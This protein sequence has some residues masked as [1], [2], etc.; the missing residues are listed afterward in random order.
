MI[1][2]LHRSTSSQL[3]RWTTRLLTGQRWSSLPFLSHPYS[4]CDRKPCYLYL[5]NRS[6]I[7]PL[8]TTS[9]ASSGHQSPGLLQKPPPH[10]PLLLPSLTRL[11]WMTS[12][13]GNLVK[14]P[15]TSCL[16]SAHNPPMVSASLRVK[17]KVLATAH[18]PLPNRT[19]NLSDFIYFYI[20]F[21]CT[22]LHLGCS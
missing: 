3:T 1:Q 17:V 18:K 14:S 10:W 13:Q 7:Q 20:L 6:Q 2:L 11:H 8:L 9:T 15:T 12:R 22:G 16:S 19:H 4:Q 5:E 21:G